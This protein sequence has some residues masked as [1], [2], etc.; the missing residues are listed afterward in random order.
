MWYPAPQDYVLLGLLSNRRLAGDLSLQ[1]NARRIGVNASYL[2]ALFKKET[3]VTLTDFVN[4]KRI[5]FAIYL[6]NASDLQIQTV[7]QH[8][9]IPDV[10]YFTRTFKKIIGITPSQYRRRTRGE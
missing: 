5:D 3:G 7:A 9:G 6:L 10:N 4:R 8:C 2:S 1:A